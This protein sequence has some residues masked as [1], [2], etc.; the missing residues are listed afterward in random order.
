MRQPLFL[1]LTV[2]GIILALLFDRR[3]ISRSCLIGIRPPSWRR[4]LWTLLSHNLRTI[5]IIGTVPVGLGPI[6]RHR[7]WSI[8]W[9]SYQWRLGCL[10][11]KRK[12]KFS[13]HL[14]ISLVPAQDELYNP[15]DHICLQYRLNRGTNVRKR[16]EFFKP[17]NAARVWSKPEFSLHVCWADATLN[18]KL[19]NRDLYPGAIWHHWKS[20]HSIWAPHW[21]FWHLWPAQ[22]VSE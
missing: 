1:F 17:W 13:A 12:T 10:L 19:E 16:M 2:V 11:C 6:H 5:S 9:V 15:L 22:W 20:H 21:D 14:H 18:E 7:E 8:A 4:T 3:S